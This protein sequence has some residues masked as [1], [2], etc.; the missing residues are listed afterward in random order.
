M[1]G[2]QRGSQEDWKSERLSGRLVIKV[3]C[4]KASPGG[5]QEDTVRE[6]CSKPSRKVWHTK[7]L[8]QSLK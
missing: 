2:N 7:V 4:R 1:P 5:W 6:A 8:V 3:A